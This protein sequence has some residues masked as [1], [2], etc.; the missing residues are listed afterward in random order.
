M[1]KIEITT[2]NK[3]STPVKSSLDVNILSSPITTVHSHLPGPVLED[4]LES[5]E[6]NMTQLFNILTTS[7][8]NK[9]QLDKTPKQS[10]KLPEG[11]NN[12]IEQLFDDDDNDSI[13]HPS[14][15]REALS[16][17]IGSII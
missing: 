15:E 11:K 12:A 17:Q 16:E 3:I 5:L 7:I 14:P 13:V 6:K 4:C 2:N 8:N 9:N 1:K 10:D